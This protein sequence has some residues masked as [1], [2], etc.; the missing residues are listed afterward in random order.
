MIAAILASLIGMIMLP[1]YA[2]VCAGETTEV[3]HMRQ[4]G[5][6]NGIAGPCHVRWTHFIGGVHPAIGWPEWNWKWTELTVIEETSRKFYCPYP[7][8][9][10][11][12][13]LSTPIA[14]YIID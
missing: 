13:P 3:W 5:W 8:A 2:A 14:E 6:V 4:A 11:H 1:L 7:L 10:G 12:C 9:T